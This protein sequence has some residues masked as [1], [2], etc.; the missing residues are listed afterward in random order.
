MQFYIASFGD[1]VPFNSF[2]QEII[3]DFELCRLPEVFDHELASFALVR[4]SFPKMVLTTDRV[5][6]GITEQGVRIENLADWLL[7]TW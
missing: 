2:V 1:A 3:L 6:L 5:R 4:D 7:S